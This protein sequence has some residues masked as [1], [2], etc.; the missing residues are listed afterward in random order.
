MSMTTSR[1]DSMAVTKILKIMI[2][3]NK[4]ELI[5]YVYNSQGPLK[6]FSETFGDDL[7]I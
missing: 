5:I 1:I 6:N 3:N 7:K 2:N 4:Q